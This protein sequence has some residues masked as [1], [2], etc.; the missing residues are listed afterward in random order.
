MVRYDGL[1]NY[2]HCLS[3][4]RKYAPYWTDWVMSKQSEQ[5]SEEA[6]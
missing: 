3:L 6:Y 2:S 1:L 5:A 4:S